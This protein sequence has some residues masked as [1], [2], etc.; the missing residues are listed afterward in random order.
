MGTTVVPPLA[1]ESRSCRR[2]VARAPSCRARVRQ[3]RSSR[4]HNGCAK[5]T[6]VHARARLAAALVRAV[7]HAPA[8]LLCHVSETF[9]ACRNKMLDTFRDPLCATSPCILQGPIRRPVVSRRARVSCASS[10]SWSGVAIA[11][12]PPFSDVESRRVKTDE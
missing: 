5:R 6:R 4:W 2:Q 8:Q 3:R 9:V 12:A 10:F 11:N 7:C 1:A